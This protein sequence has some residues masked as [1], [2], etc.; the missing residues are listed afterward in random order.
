MRP[1]AA[2]LRNKIVTI[3]GQ[4]L[5][6]WS[7]HGLANQVSKTAAFVNSSAAVSIDV[8]YSFCCHPV[9]GGWP[10]ATE[11]GGIEGVEDE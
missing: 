6:A 2:T 7:N 10:G 9:A 1:D 5:S 11:S 8:R 4:S 3:S